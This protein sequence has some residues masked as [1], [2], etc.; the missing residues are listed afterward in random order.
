M[1]FAQCEES[2]SARVST[3][4][5]AQTATLLRD[6]APEP[7]DKAA[8]WMRLRI[9]GGAAEVLSMGGTGH[10]KYR[11]R[12]TATVECYAPAK[13]GAATLRAVGDAVVAAFR[14]VASA[15]PDIRYL[16][17]TIGQFQDQNGWVRR[18]VTVPFIFD[19]EG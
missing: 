14:G 3:V 2:I 4:A 18:D 12:G 1:T 5:T 13:Q 7:A 16:P 17:P 19:E 11:V 10:R 15:S 8:K 9:G 6:N